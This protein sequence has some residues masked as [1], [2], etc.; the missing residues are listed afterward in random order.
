MGEL[1]ARY[2][3]D[4][5]GYRGDKGEI[6]ARHLGGERVNLRLLRLVRVRG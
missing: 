2:R 6:S 1:W 5:W 3:G 4:I